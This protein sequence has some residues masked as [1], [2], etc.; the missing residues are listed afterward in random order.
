[1]Q[2]LHRSLVDS[3]EPVNISHCSKHQ[4]DRDKRSDPSDAPDVMPKFRTAITPVV[5]V[6]T[7]LV[8]MIHSSLELHYSVILRE[9]STEESHRES[10]GCQSGNI[11]HST[12]F[13]SE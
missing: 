4:K 3:A 11:L 13:R 7:V 12:A 5:V 9:S 2:R 1:M 10:Y 6:V 8:G